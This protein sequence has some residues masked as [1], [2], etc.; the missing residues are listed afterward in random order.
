MVSDGRELPRHCPRMQ[1]HRAASHT[2]V[3]EKTQV[4]QLAIAGGEPAFRDVLHVG[5]P[6]I[7]NRQRLSERIHDLLDRRWLT[8]NGQ[9]VQEFERQVASRIGVRHCVAV[10][11]GTI[12]LEI[13]I[14]ALELR[15]EVIVPSFTFAATVHALRWLGITPSLLRRGSTD[16][17]DGFS[18]RRGTRDAADNGAASGAR[19]GRSVQRQRACRD[20]QATRSA[21]ALRRRSRVRLLGT[22]AA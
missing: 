21:S 14:R 6:N 7:G 17:Y 16:P 2:K 5:R 10:C 22:R 3:I 9:Y 11:N 4:G 15:G 20:C 8:N 1:T 13:A 12:G 19:L 18:T